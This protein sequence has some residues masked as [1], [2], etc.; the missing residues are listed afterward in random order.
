MCPGKAWPAEGG[1]APLSAGSVA[2]RP[3]RS[4]NSEQLLE[5][6]A[7]PS[8]QVCPGQSGVS[9]QEKRHEGPSVHP[10]PT[11]THLG[12]GF[13][14]TGEAPC[15]GW[16]RVRPLGLDPLLSC[17]WRGARAPPFLTAPDP[18]VRGPPWVVSPWGCEPSHLR[19][20]L[21]F[22]ASFPAPG[23]T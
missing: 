9:S 1:T 7:G 17:R 6:L 13:P 5:S 11:A 16:P 21:L 19:S 4:G 12:Q 23:H 15:S 18:H 2:A 10:C 3:L 22:K 8:V 14:F 20:S